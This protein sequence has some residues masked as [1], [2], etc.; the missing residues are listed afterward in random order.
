MLTFRKVNSEIALSSG[1]K[2]CASPGELVYFASSIVWKNRLVAISE[3]NILFVYTLEE[4]EWSMKEIPP[5]SLFVP[6]VTLPKLFLNVKN[7]L[8]L[9]GRFNWTW[10]VWCLKH[11]DSTEWDQM[12]NEYVISSDEREFMGTLPFNIVSTMINANREH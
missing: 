5:V 6:F 1:W 7:H 10:Q 8:C 3:S 9:S 2:T 11:F 12:P 4:D